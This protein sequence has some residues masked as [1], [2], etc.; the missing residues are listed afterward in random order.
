[1][2]GHRDL[3]IIERF[4][5]GASAGVIAQTAIYPLEVLKTR[6]ALRRFFLCNS[7]NS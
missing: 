1:M 2:T 6:L 4:M 7:Q 3:G 5:A